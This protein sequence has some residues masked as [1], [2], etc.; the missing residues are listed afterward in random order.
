MKVSKK[1][2][3]ICFP[4]VN[5]YVVI[6]TAPGYAF[7]SPRSKSLNKVSDLFKNAF[8][9]IIQGMRTALFHWIKGIRSHLKTQEMCTNIMRIGPSSLA[10]IPD[11]FKTQEMSIKAVEKDPCMLKYVPDPFKT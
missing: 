8:W 2:F 3:W 5:L 9:Y 11:R 4:S 1:T 7:V 10:Y 6:I